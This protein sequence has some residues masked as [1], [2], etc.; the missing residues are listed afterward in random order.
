VCRATIRRLQCQDPRVIARY[1][2]LLIERLDQGHLQQQVTE[3]HAGILGRLTSAQQQL[4]EKLDSQL[5]KAKL[6]AEWNCRKLKMGQVQWCPDVSRAIN[7]I[8][9]WKGVLRRMVGHRIRSSV[10][11]T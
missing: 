6:Y 11:R 3:F 1:N 7:W 9:F 4:Y 10:L 8:L 2:A 5:V